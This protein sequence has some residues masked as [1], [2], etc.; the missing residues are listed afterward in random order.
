MLSEKIRSRKKNFKKTNALCA[1]GDVVK[2]IKH[3][4]AGQVMTGIV[5]KKNQK[6]KKVL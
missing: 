4:K 5:V 3:G 6:D 2:C 1:V